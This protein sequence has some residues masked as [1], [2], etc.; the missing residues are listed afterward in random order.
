MFPLA[1]IVLEQQ[2]MEK[3]Y[4]GQL[5][6]ITRPKQRVNIPR[7]LLCISSSICVAVG[8]MW[9]PKAPGLALFALGTT[10]HYF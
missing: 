6:V 4:K 1:R 5:R 8:D 10:Q 3:V 7:I 9:P 2:V